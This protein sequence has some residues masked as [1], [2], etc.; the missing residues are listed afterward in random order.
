MAQEK[1]NAMRRQTNLPNESDEYLSKREELRLAEIELMRHRERVAELRRALPQGA[2]IQDYAFEEGPANL[3]AGD[4]P[5]RTVRLSELFS[6]PDISLV[7]YHFMFGKK[8]TTPCPM[9]T[10]W[11]DG[12]NGVAHHL[13]R[14]PALRQSSG[15]TPAGHQVR[16]WSEYKTAWIPACAGMT[17]TEFDFQSTNSE[18]LRLGA[19]SCSVPLSARPSFLTQLRRVLGGL[20][21]ALVASFLPYRPAKVDREQRSG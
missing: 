4:T 11:I 2:A 18:P 16:S 15:Y 3:D 19:E 8:Q 17:E 1:I 21:K 9:C 12:W 6:A 20:A 14:M 7:V 13:A 10:L 5:I